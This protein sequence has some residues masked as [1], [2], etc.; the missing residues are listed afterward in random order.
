MCGSALRTQVHGIARL[1]T[2]SGRGV[3]VLTLEQF[4]NKTRWSPCSV[5]HMNHYIAVTQANANYCQRDVLADHR[6]TS[7]T[8]GALGA[9]CQ[10]VRAGG[11][12]VA[13]LACIAATVAAY[14]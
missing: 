3:D 11:R 6:G 12:V 8:S 7:A 10:W 4:G 9:L 14:S 1:L 5:G 2:G 13:T